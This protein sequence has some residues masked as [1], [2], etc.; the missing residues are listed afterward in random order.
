MFVYGR[1]EIGKRSCTDHCQS[2]SNRVG[3]D[4]RR[5]RDRVDRE[6]IGYQSRISR[7]DRVPIGTKKYSPTPHDLHTIASRS[8][9]S[10]PDLYT[11]DT[12]S[13]PDHLTTQPL[14]E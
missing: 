1:V 6:V 13:L 2:D 7:D 3:L 12:R 5:N 14:H 8:T 4:N 9:R 10:L 11:I